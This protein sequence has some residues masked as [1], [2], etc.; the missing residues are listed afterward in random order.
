MPQ[1]EQRLENEN[2]RLALLGAQD[3]LG[4]GEQP[5]MHPQQLLQTAVRSERATDAAFEVLGAAGPEFRAAN[6]YHQK[7]RRMYFWKDM[8]SR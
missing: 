5:R 4:L 7:T 1:V 8:V 6:R 3:S 2:A